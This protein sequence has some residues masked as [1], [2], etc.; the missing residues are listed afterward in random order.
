MIS[1]L[2]ATRAD[3]ICAVTAAALSVV[4]SGIIILLNVRFKE[5]RDNFFRSLIFILSIYDAIISFSFMIPGSVG[6]AFCKFQG[7]FIV[8]SALMPVFISLCI[9]IITYLN[10][11]RRWTKKQLKTLF[12]KMHIICNVLALGIMFFSI[13]FADSVSFPNTNW[14]FIKGQEMLGTFYITIWICTI[15]SFILYLLIVKKIREIY[16]ELDGLVDIGD[17]SRKTENLKVQF[18]MSTIPLSLIFTWLIASIRRTR[19]IFWE[20]PKQINTLNILQSLTNPMQGLFDCFVFVIFSSYSRKKVK[21]L[22]CCAES[23]KEKYP[24]EIDSDSKL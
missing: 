8:Y 2:L 5:Y 13:L 9:A 17:K 10:V 4:G 21:E 3:L 15:I 14:C 7:Y 20:N 16:K 23:E 1:L 18:R 6:K 22:I 11:V 24:P 19:E 12:K